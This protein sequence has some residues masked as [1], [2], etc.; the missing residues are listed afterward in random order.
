MTINYIYKNMSNDDKY[1]EKSL[2]EYPDIITLQKTEKIVEQMKNCIFKI[3]ISD[4]GIGTGFFCNIKNIKT[5]QTMPVMITNNHVIGQ[6][7]FN[8]RSIKISFNNEEKIMDIELDS[9]RKKYTNKKYDITIIEIKK[10]D[11]INKNS[12]LEIDDNIYQ[13]NPFDFFTKKSVYILQY[14]NYR[15]ASV[16]YG[17]INQICQENVLH[18]YCITDKGSSGSPIINLENSKVI[19]IHNGGSDKFNFNKGIFLK[20]PINGF[21]SENINFSC[22][23]PNYNVEKKLDGENEEDNLNKNEIEINLKIDKDDIEKE[24]FFLDNTNEYV[25]NN[26]K[27]HFN[28]TE[29]NPSNTDLFI[30]NQKI[31]YQKFFIPK[32]EDK[33]IIKLKFKNDLKNC[34]YMFYY[35]RNI[36]DINFKYFKTDNITNM[37]KMFCYCSNLTTLDLSTFK[38]KNVTNMSNMFSFCSNLKRINLS[39]FNVKNVT[40]IEGMFSLCQK[41]EFI[42]ISSFIVS[43]NI[44]THSIFDRCRNLKLLKINKKSKDV[45]ARDTK[46]IDNIQY[47]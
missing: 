10:S 41:L 23:I 42:D 28:L 7:Y 43:P 27:S 4:G 11:K 25:D 1:L 31:D 24:I 30:N 46:E 16:S 39:S 44:K 29:L 45:F 2:K 37:S 14:P 32:I 8:N 15:G 40:N 3:H 33:Y 21:F 6:E 38:T 22:C 34:S 19:G 36:I 35:C 5:K 9:S 18:H 26:K 47:V 17:L 13:D 12:F 20:A